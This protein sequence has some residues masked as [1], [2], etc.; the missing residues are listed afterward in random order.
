MSTLRVNRLRNQETSHGYASHST[1][2]DWWIVIIVMILSVIGLTMIYSASSVVADRSYGDKFFFLKRQ[3]IFTAVSLIA[4]VITA[5]L[6]RKLLNQLH[7]VGLIIVSFLLFLCITPLGNEVN[8]A[9]RWL[10]FGAFSIQPLEFTKIALVLYLAYFMSEKRSTFNSYKLGML[11][12][13]L[14][15][16]F[17]CGLIILQPDFGG[18]IILSILL[19]FMCLVGGTKFLYIFGTFSLIGATG[20]LFLVTSPYRMQRLLAFVDPFKDALD[21]GY[22]LVQSF[23][24]LAL[25]GFFGVGVGGSTQKLLYL[26]EAHNDFIMAI[27]GEEMGFFTITVIMLLFTLLFARCFRLV[28]GQENMRDKF[29]VFGISL[30]IGIGALLNLAVVLGSIPPT[31]V[32]MPFIS[33]GGS[34]LL[35][36]MICVGLLLNYSRTVK[37]DQVNTY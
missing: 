26:P 21:T 33:Y 30:V 27:I 1:S 2:I 22:Q 37:D 5:N 16:M 35:S 25:G 36:S 29:T 31:G 10:S 13:F 19:F 17:L 28:L 6:P 8:G 24:A 3:L 32:A 18:T 23:Y 9:S 15:T 34:S 4:M 7:Y 11:P 20:L 14:V 12:P